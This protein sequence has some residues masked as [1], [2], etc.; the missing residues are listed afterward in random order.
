MARRYGGFRRCAAARAKAAKS[1]GRHDLARQAAAQHTRQRLAAGY[2]LRNAGASY[3]RLSAPRS[4]ARVRQ[5]Q[6][7]TARDLL[8]DRLLDVLERGEA[9]AF[10]GLSQRGLVP[11]GNRW[12]GGRQLADGGIATRAAVGRGDG[13]SAL[14]LQGASLFHLLLDHAAKREQPLVDR[15]GHF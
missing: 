8:P 1:A 9:G 13:V 3:R 4:R 14:A 12:L 6:R 10:L 5:R 2:G 11:A 7:K 15:G